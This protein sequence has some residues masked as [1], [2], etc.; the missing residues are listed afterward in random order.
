MGGLMLRSTYR[1]LPEIVQR[2]ISR[3][4]WHAHGHMIGGHVMGVTCMCLG[5]SCV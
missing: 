3:F 4:S 5:L 1:I 2:N